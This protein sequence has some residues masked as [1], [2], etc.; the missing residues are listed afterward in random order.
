MTGT[1]HS[2]EPDGKLAREIAE[3]G[4][5]GERHATRTRELSRLHGYDT[6][7]AMHALRIAYQGIE[8]LT[9]G[10]ITL[11]VPEPE[12]SA[13]RRVRAGEQPLDDVLAHLDG[14]TTRLEE[15][16]DGA[17]LPAKPDVA[18]VDAFIVRA[19]RT[20]WEG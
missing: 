19:Y 20:S 12:R 16:T 14:V 17:D 5:T 4:L 18:A 8:L 3:R 7:Y 6:K 2:L 9:T 1:L 13:L 11:P 15:V 10:R